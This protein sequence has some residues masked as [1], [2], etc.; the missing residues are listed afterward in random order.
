MQVLCCAC[1][2]TLCGAGS[3]LATHRVQSLLM[4]CLVAACSVAVAL[5]ILAY[6]SLTN[7]PAG[8]G[9]GDFT[10]AAAWPGG[11]TIG[12]LLADP[13]TGTLIAGGADG[14]R[15]PDGSLRVVDVR[16]AFG[17]KYVAS[18]AED[19]VWRDAVI[20]LLPD[21]WLWTGNA[22]YFDSSRLNCSAAAN[23]AAAECACAP[24]GAYAPLATPA[25][26]CGGGRRPA[27]RGGHDGRVPGAAGLCLSVLLLD[28][29]RGAPRSAAGGVPAA[30]PRHLRHPRLVRRDGGPELSG[31]RSRQAGALSRHAAQPPAAA[32]H[33]PAYL[34]CLHAAS[35]C[36]VLRPLRLRARR[37]TALRFV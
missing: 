11:P 19:A 26:L 17:S 9:A 6:T 21:A 24:A 35:A 3:F 28:V 30:G 23:A 20:P 27:R 10:A 16:I 14:G 7:A 2:A 4:A 22:A 5:S 37:N 31:A 32:R 29:R 12:E 8:D 34:P 15:A 1:S 36:T 13:D 18:G 33:M 25:P